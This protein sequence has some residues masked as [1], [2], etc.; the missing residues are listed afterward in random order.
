VNKAL[1]HDPERC[2]GCGSCQLACAS[3]PGVQDQVSNSPFLSMIDI[4]RAG[5]GYK[6]VFC[7]SCRRPLCF[8]ACPAGATSPREDGGVIYDAK[9]CI[10]CWMCVMA[11]PVGGVRPLGDQVV[12]CDGCGE[13]EACPCVTACLTGALQMRHKDG[14]FSRV[15]IGGRRP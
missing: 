13:S 10:A 15:R 6:A 9:R 4:A 5:A 3:R 8:E 11:C 7:R 2:M 12:R 1:T 14:A